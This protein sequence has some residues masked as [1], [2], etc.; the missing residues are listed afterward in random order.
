VLVVAALVLRRAWLLG[1]FPPG[2]DGGQWLAIGRG[3]LAG[4][5]RSTPGAYAP[6]VPVATAS[7]AEIVGSVD[8]VR[9]VALGSYALV[10]ATIAVVVGAA[11]GGFVGAATAAAMGSSGALN[12]PLAFGG[13]PQQVALAALVVAGWAA[14][15]Q[16]WTEGRANLAVV[17][18]GLVIAALAHHVYYPLALAVVAAVCGLA[19]VG[20]APGARRNVPRLAALAVASTLLALPTFA[21]FSR[22]G[23]SPP[24]EAVG[25]SI[26]DAWRYG[27]REAPILWLGVVTAGVAG[28]LGSLV[29]RP[30]APAALA[31]ALLA[32]GGASFALSAEP[33]LLPLLLLGGLLGLPLGLAGLARFTKRGT[34]RRLVT[35]VP[36]L[37]ALLLASPGDRATRDYLGFYRVLE[38]S[39]VSAANRI[40]ELGLPVAVRADR[41]GWPLG[42]W[43]EGLTTVPVA[44]GS[45]P[46]WLG[47][48]DEQRTAA[49]AVE[50]FD[51]SLSPAELRSR[52]DRLGV[53]L[54]LVRKWEWIGWERWLAAEEP[55]VE[56]LF[57]DGDTLLLRVL[58]AP[59]PAGEARI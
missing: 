48:P 6:L 37:L 32:V 34:A 14:A 11:F 54:L 28:S 52:A 38:P 39:L 58:P 29:T 43:L 49:D 51:G 45:D 35:A 57:D 10:V 4:E 46:R 31:L 3:L 22:L 2:L 30:S 41:R 50:L 19:A 25:L 1:P 8:A 53:E 40:E 59:D 17:A 23:Y 15:R 20:R 47:F 42:W 44:V 36:A 16:C 24:L 21:A 27:T 12:E 7:L 33:R 13:Y 5:G 55:A 56:P 9:L 26:G 18:L